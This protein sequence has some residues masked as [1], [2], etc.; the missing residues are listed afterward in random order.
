VGIDRDGLI[1][2][3][4][5]ALIAVSVPIAT[6]VVAAVAA[7]SAAAAGTRRIVHLAFRG[8]NELWD[9]HVAWELMHLAKPCGSVGLQRF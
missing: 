3:I 5:A 9:Y 6:V 1:A 4:A 7:A 8:V 2:I